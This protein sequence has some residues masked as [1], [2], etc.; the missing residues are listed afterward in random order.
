MNL[1]GSWVRPRPDGSCLRSRAQCAPGRY[2]NGSGTENVI[3]WM[4][5]P[6]HFAK[7]SESDVPIMMKGDDLCRILCPKLVLPATNQFYLPVVM[8]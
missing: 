6:G 2:H 3:V 7:C 8:I 1:Y 5:S 4:M